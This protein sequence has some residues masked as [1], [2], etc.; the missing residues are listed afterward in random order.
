[1][2]IFIDIGHPAHVHYFRNFA[3]IMEN[4]GHVILISARDR[5]MIHYLLKKYN[6]DFF[7]RGKGQNGFIGKLFYM[8]YADFL[9]IKKAVHFKPEL[10]LSFASPYAAQAAWVMRKPHIVLD[11]TEHAKISQI[12]YKPFSTTFLNPFCFYSNFGSKQI[13]FNSFVECLYLHSNYFKPDKNVY[14]ML[15]I[16]P[17]IKFVILRFV[18]WKAN[19]DI[20]QSGLSEDTKHELVNLLKTKYK[21]FISSE[22][23]LKDEILSDYVITIPPE[24]I[25]HALSY[26]DFFITESGTMASEAAI[27]NTPVVYVNSLPLMGYLKEEQS[28]GMLFHF[29]NSTGVVSKVNELMRLD[30]IKQSFKNKN[31][32]LLTDRIDP[33]QFLVWY[34]ENYP[35]CNKILKADPTFQEKFINI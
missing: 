25:H 32:N 13:R 28:Y 9:I 30:N 22:E 26:A 16:E 20:G 35:D 33:T 5:S 34:I 18:S 4:K 1:M 8:I 27:L 3:K 10:F 6:F 21:V 17:D 24:M 11:D 31:K 2:K 12:F 29:V 14:S 23:A 15:N 19:H 7:T